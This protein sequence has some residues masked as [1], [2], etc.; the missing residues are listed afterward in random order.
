MEKKNGLDAE[1]VVDTIKDCM[2]RKNI[3]QTELL[4]RCKEKGYLI[5]QSGVSKVLNKTKKISVEEFKAF[6]D[7]LKLSA[8]ELFFGTQK[9]CV[10]EDA[11]FLL[12][13]NTIDSVKGILGQYDMYFASTAIEENLLIKGS[14]NLYCKESCV[15][16]EASIQAKN[17]MQK[18]YTGYLWIGNPRKVAYIILKQVPFGEMSVLAIRYREFQVEK[19]KCRGALCL[20]TS[21]GEMKDPIA[22]SVVLIRH[23]WIRKHDSSGLDE[24]IHEILKSEEWGSAFY[25]RGD[26][27]IEIYQYLRDME[28]RYDG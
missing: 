2:Q 16:A 9:K 14:L 11:F 5:T 26:R 18:Q 22:H 25:F 21:A 19:M 15:L 4:K 24:K 17:T 27:D 6:C 12:D 23:E 28:G 10:K 13:K 20:T 1:T 3:S 8:D 7:V